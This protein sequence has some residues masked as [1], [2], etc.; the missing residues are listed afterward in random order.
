MKFS[1]IEFIYEIFK[2]YI[3]T[4][5][6]VILT[7]VF[8]YL[9]SKIFPKLVLKLGLEFAKQKYES[10]ETIG[11]EL[12]KTM[13]ML[14][15]NRVCLYRCYNGKNYYDKN[16]NGNKF[17]I[18]EMEKM[19]KRF[20]KS[21]DF[22]PSILTHTDYSEFIQQMIHDENFTIFYTTELKD[23]KTKANFSERNIVAY[24]IVKLEI[25]NKI[26][27]FVLYTWGVTRDIPNVERKEV[28]NLILQTKRSNREYLEY[29]QAVVLNLLINVVDRT[30][31][32]NIVNQI[33][34][35]K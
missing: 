26:Y 31:F 24:S 6:Y 29:M 12:I 28:S 27:G 3:Q 18:E 20:N 23:Y 17:I 10:Y 19:N 1:N 35:V 14:K 11:S 32:S 30:V 13:T 7:P 25:E 22:L 2:G 33:K 16:S 34:G 21:Y 9:I 15:S 4:I 8:F 5:V